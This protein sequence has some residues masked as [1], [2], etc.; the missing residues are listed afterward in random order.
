M[1][2][3]LLMG[4]IAVFLLASC[5]KSGVKGDNTEAERELDKTKTEYEAK[6]T[7]IAETEARLNEVISELEKNKES[8]STE[9]PTPDV[10]E[11]LVPDDP[12]TLVPEVSETPVPEVTVTPTPEI[13]VT[14]IPK[15]TLTPTLK[16]TATPTFTP[17][18]TKPAYT[19]K[20]INPVTM[21]ASNGVNVRNTPNV[22]GKLVGSLEKGDAVTVTGQCTESG[23]YR[24]LYGDSVAYVSNSYILKSAPTNSPTPKPATPT[25]KPA[26]VTTK[27]AT[28]TPK[29]AT[30]TPTP[31]T[32][33]PIIKV[34]VPDGTENKKIAE[35]A[36]VHYNTYKAYYNEVVRL[37]NIIRAEAGV[38]PVELDETLCIA[39]GIRAIEMDENNYFDHSRP[40]GRSSSTAVDEV[41]IYWFSYAENIAWNY[42]SPAEVVE[43][44]KNSAGHYANM[45]NKKYGSIGIGYSFRY[46]NGTFWVQ[47]FTD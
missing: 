4:L 2:K 31:A 18:S 5:G 20:E 14:P 46:N 22:G 10:T 41:G 19:I 27:P 16:P 32:L 36:K 47:E 15:A 34:K 35:Q 11:T 26:T 30:S 17:V 1:K 38:A 37:V 43:A 13:T 7:E 45:I 8:A 39:A 21:Y 3:K 42:T 12:K 6:L 29:A 44:W 40:D 9:A 25:P 33:T 24:I 23:W 28:S